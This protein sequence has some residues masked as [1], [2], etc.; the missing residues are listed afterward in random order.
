MDTVR[1]GAGELSGD[2]LKEPHEVYARLRERGPVHW[3]RLPDGQEMWL[4]VGYEVARAALADARLSKDLTKIGA[5]SFDQEFLGPHLLVSDP[6]QHTRLRRLVSKEFT[7]R[8]VEAMAGGV[9]R[10][11]DGLLDAMQAE[12]RADLVADFAFPLSIGVICELLGVPAMDRESF[13]GWSNAINAPV[14]LAAKV[15][16]FGQLKGYLGELVAVKRDEPGDD[17]LSALIRATDED[18]DRLTGAELRAM[19]YLLLSAGHETTVNLITNAVLTL[20]RH[21]DQLAALRAD[22]SLV[23]GAVEEVLRFEGPIESA[24][25][26]FALERVEIGGVA[27]ETGDP[28][29]VVLASANRDETRFSDPGRFD[30]RRDG[31]G[32]LAFGHGVHYCLGAPLARMEGRIA[33][34]ALLERFPG[35]MVDVAQDELSWLPG[36]LLRGVRSLPVSWPAGVT[37]EEL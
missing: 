25:F 5:S 18:S 30:V 4:V 20:V 8:R 12:G 35:I 23:D 29:L 22:P 28:V 13:R 27:V 36:T 21:P 15:E 6:P 34:R 17:L 3:V 33:I 19:A 24:T 26:R 31:G 32:H 16:A 37:T 2:L 10:Q 11:V 1:L 9:R 7:P 14:G